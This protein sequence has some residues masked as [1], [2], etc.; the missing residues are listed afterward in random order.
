MLV[1]IDEVV[2]GRVVEEDEAE[3]DGEAADCWTGP[4]KGGVGGPGEDEEA[5]GNEPAGT[6]HGDETYFGGW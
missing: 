3:A 5:D 2:I 1:G 6:H 4:A